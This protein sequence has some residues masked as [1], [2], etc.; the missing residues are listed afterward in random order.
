[1]K[2]N[3]PDSW[4]QVTVEQYS[5]IK[6]LNITDNLI[7][8]VSVLSGETVATVETFAPESWPTIID[9]MAWYFK[10]P[11]EKLNKAITIEEKE[12]FM[13]N[14]SDLTIREW[15]DLSAYIRDQKNNLHKIFS[16]LY[17]GDPEVFMKANIADLYG[18]LVFFSHIENEYL[19][20]LQNYLMNQMKTPAKWMRV[21]T[22]MSRRLSLG[23]SLHIAWRRGSLQT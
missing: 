23:M 4:S 14:L 11:E 17:K 22:W 16:V 19:I 21:K 5:N 7:E 20:N 13:M 6:G 10:L 9:K 1:M 15:I 8:I 2:I 12:Y 3:L 18:A